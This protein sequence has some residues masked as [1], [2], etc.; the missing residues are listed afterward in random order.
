[1]SLAVMVCS[2]SHDLQR[3]RFPLQ[4]VFCS[5][6]R[7]VLHP[8]L[9]FLDWYLVFKFLQSSFFEKQGKKT[10]TQGHNVLLISK[11]LGKTPIL[12]GKLGKAQRTLLPQGMILSRLGVGAMSNRSFLELG[13]H[14]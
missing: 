14:E 13:L 8:S 3:F 7:K 11:I 1:M 9:Y 4:L 5:T 6:F 12:K 10:N 2:D